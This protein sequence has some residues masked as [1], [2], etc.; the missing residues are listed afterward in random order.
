M[1]PMQRESAAIPVTVGTASPHDQ[2]NNQQITEEPISARDILFI[3]KL[4]TH[5]L[6]IQLSADGELLYTSIR[7]SDPGKL[8]FEIIRINLT[9]FVKLLIPLKL[10]K[11]RN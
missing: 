9:L 4:S 5:S 7:Q 3:D 10:N 11:I 8:L 6:E 2:Q 1:T